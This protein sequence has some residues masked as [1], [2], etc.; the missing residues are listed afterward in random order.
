LLQENA[1]R[2]I[3][4][5]FGRRFS[6]F[7]R[8]GLSRDT[9]YSLRQSPTRQNCLLERAFTVTPGKDNVVRAMAESGIRYI[10]PFDVI[11]NLRESSR[12]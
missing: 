4:R 2:P 8:V 11:Q 1:P 10:L 12:G 7:E 6:D 3:V 9:V 5:D